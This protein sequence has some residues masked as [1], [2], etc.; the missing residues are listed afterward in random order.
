MSAALQDDELA[1]LDG[2][3]GAGEWTVGGDRVRLTN[4]DKVLFPGTGDLAPVTKRD[5]VRYLVQVS[6]HLLPYLADRAVHLQRFP[7]GA[8]AEGFWT[9]A[10]PPRAPP[11]LQRWRDP[12]ATADRTQEYAVLD[13]PAALAYVANL[14]ALELHPWTARIDAPDEPTWALIDIDPG[15][16]T[17]FEEVVTLA[18]LHRTALQHV[19]VDAAA[20]VTGKR[21]IQ[22]WIPVASGMTF[23]QTQSWVHDLSRLVASAVPH[24]V[25]WEWSTSR[26]RGLARLDYTQNA[27]A[28]TLVA[29]FSTRPAPGAPVSMPISWAELDDPDLQ[30]DRWTV[31]TALERIQQVGDPMRP[32]IGRQQHLP[33]LR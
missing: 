12:S 9:K 32:L 14:G 28:H 2:L 16:T 30:P 25:S 19:G 29:P 22:I 6:P 17:T 31:H 18:R 33:D 15:P 26:R 5:L 13:R 27:P 10:V 1:T 21:G 24:L 4:L 23:E 7:D 8:D 20:K 11:W 3:G